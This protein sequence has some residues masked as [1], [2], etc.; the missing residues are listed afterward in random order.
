MKC[1]CC[2]TRMISVNKYHSGVYPMT[3]YACPECKAGAEVVI[4]TDG[5]IK[6]VKFDKYRKF[7]DFELKKLEEATNEREDN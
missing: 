6:T 3:V 4:D 5:S 2:N 7:Y 1:L